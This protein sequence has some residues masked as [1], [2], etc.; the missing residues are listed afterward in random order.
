LFPGVY[1]GRG[2]KVIDTVVMPKVLIGDNVTIERSI[3]GLESVIENGCR[4]GN[5]TTKSISLVGEHEQ[6]SEGSVRNS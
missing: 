6:I 3:I 1:V 4:I 5:S 2:T